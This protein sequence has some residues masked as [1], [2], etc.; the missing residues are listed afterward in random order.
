LVVDKDKSLSEKPSLDD[1]LI[2]HGDNLHALKALLPQYAGNVDCIFIDPPYNTG[3]EGWCYNDNVNSP[4]IREWLKKSANPVD[5]EDLER[6]DKWLS[7]MLPRLKLLRE[8]LSESGSIWIT[9]DDNEIHRLRQLMDDVF[10]EE[11][12]VACCVWEKTYTPKSNGSVVSTDH[13]YVLC[14]QKTSDFTSFG[15]NYLDR[16]EEQKGRFRKS[17]DE[18]L[19]WRTYPLDVRTE[20]SAR[21]EKYRY[22]VTLPSGRV[23]KPA[24]ERHWALPEAEFYRQRD[25]GEIY[26]GKTGD[27][28]PSKKVFLDPEDDKGVIARSWWTYKEVKGNQDSKRDLLSITGGDTDFIT[29]KPKELIQ[30]ILDIATH[31]ESIILD[32]FAGSGTTA[33]AVL[34]TNA[35]DNGRRHFI[36]VECE[37]YAETLT[38]NRVRKV[39]EGYNFKGRLKEELY[40]INLTWSAFEKKHEKILEQISAI[41]S[42]R[43]ADF[44][45]M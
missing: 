13:D 30:R 17:D 4:L 25:A 8:L 38:A 27:A 14:Y 12:F 18:D 35:K 34:A 41:E 45:K 29:P 5:K 23:V 31:E 10:G 44:E 1:N 6:H 16:N 26:F 21:R 3:N 15:W 24:Q 42:S 39:I 22:E 43:A 9:L 36:L 19:P 37:D 28:M 32:S 33:H 40:S 11:N 2:I 7:M 20:N